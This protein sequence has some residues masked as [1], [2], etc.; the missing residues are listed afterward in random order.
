M[1][2]Q[3]RIAGALN[4]LEVRPGDALYVA[5]SGGVDSVA[6]A[7][8]IVA[9]GY[10]PQALLSVDHGL[11]SE[12]ERRRDHAIVADLA[13]HLGVRHLALAAAPGVI[14]DRADREG[15]GVEAAARAVRY[16]LMC[17]AIRRDRVG[18]AADG[19]V[20]LVTAHHRRDQAETVLMRLAAGHAAVDRLGMPARRIVD[21]G[22][23]PI[24]VVR[25]A[26]GI[27]PEELR[28]VAER[29]GLTWANDSS[30]RDS[31]FRRNAI[32]R[33]VLPPLEEAVPQAI[34]GLARAA[35][36]HEALMDA[37]DALIPEDAW[38]RFRADGTQWT[39]SRD[40]LTEL[41]A[42]ARERVLRRAAYTV[43]PATRVSAGILRE[44][45]LQLNPATDQSKDMPG[46][47][48][49]RSQLSCTASGLVIRVTDAAVTVEAAVVRE[50]QSGYLWPV[51]DGEEIVFQTGVGEDAP[52][53]VA[54]PADAEESGFHCGVRGLSV[55]AVVRPR[56]AGD[57]IRRRGRWMSPGEIHRSV[58]RPAVCEDRQGIGFFLWGDGTVA[59]CDRLQRIDDPTT[60]RATDVSIRVRG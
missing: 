60:L 16:R 13:V 18:S 21:A 31:R 14:G 12:V 34:A 8:L 47:G 41:P 54:D 42:A 50:G 30:N 52:T 17:D 24:V 3:N 5:V 32:R 4:R 29:H 36:D 44:L 20:F 15:I 19:N 22:P 28:A 10:A 59:V 25:P 56:R 35:A 23:P 39:V 43:S 38:G 48:T 1:T 40:A 7:A 6:L 37:V 58:G 45:E 2:L 51:Y 11:R 57:R 53:P 49:P 33:A 9:A 27:A 55:P 46:G 26:L